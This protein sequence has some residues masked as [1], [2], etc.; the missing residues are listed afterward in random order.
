MLF[1]HLLA[2]LDL[3]H[4]VLK[5]RVLMGSMHVGLEDALG[6]L[7][8]L[9]AYFARRAEGGVGL[10]VTGGIA[11]N[12]EGWL[13]PFAA[14]LSNRLE[15]AQ[16]RYVTDAVHEAGGR[17][18]LQILHAGRYGYHPLAVSASPLQSPISPFKPRQL[19]V[20]GIGRTVQAFVDCARLAQQAGYDG[21]EIM[22]SE[23]Y[24][25]HQ[26]IARR[27]NQRT[28]AWG[29]SAEGRFRFPLEIVRRT[30]EAVGPEFIVIFRLSMLDLVEEGSTWE[31]VVD[32]AR[33][34][35]A[36]GVTMINTG[37]GWHESRV[38]TIATRVPRAGFSW[39]TARLKAEVSVPL[40][41]SN[42]IHLPDV[43]E[44]V[45]ARG[46][47]DMVSM[48]RPLLADPDWVA[49]AAAGKPETINPCIACNQACLD[50]VFSNRRA[51]C[52]VNPF[53][54]Q[55]TEWKVQPVRARRK[56]AVVGAG[57]AGLSC[58][59]LAAE[60][61]H[62]VV[63]FEADDT[64]GGQFRLAAKIPGKEEFNETLAYYRTMIAA[65][66]VELRL[67]TPATVEALRGFDAVVLATGVR[68]RA[69]SLPGI[70][71]AA[72]YAEVLSG[73]REVGPRVAI[74][75]AGGIGFD[76]AEYLAHEG[77]SPYRSDA[78]CAGGLAGARG[79]GA[80]AAGHPVPAVGGPARR[81]PRE[82]H[83]LDPPGVAEGAAGRDARRV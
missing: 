14:K 56:I 69:L 61:G 23:G 62:A 47:A 11:P 43:A 32:L 53:A 83:R 46:D 71:R 22:G 33:Q 60:R 36:A 15:V 18:C 64:I 27:T 72:S 37:V 49:K 34:L 2:P 38:P 5:N 81:E 66:G 55:E 12:R 19:S 50:H 68:P 65:H 28:D 54:C 75:G 70:E 16:H 63:L 7:S 3:G 30:R 26:F 67:S 4:V 1:P 45:L 80:G 31:E 10:M 52:L 25:I 76:V 6:P 9:G 13:K 78:G 82:D 8:K 59:T 73:A 21:V 57:P 51:G 39:V 74:I 42:R 79:A 40:I 35:E 29:A 20:R 58:A 24:L 41:T 48:A 77:V 44:A 17:I